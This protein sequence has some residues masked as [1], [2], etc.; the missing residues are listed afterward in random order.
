M[1]V[2]D[3]SAAQLF[4]TVRRYPRTLQL[5]AFRSVVAG[6][7][8]AILL[9][10]GLTLQSVS[11]RFTIA[12]VPATEAQIKAQVSKIK[13]IFDGDPY[14]DVSATEYLAI[15]NH[16]NFRY[17]LTNVVD[18][19]LTISPSRPWDQEISAQDGPAWG[20]ATNIGGGVRTANLEITLAGGATIDLIDPWAEVTEAEPM[21]RH[22]T[23]R[24]VSSTFAAAGDVIFSDWPVTGPD[25]SAYALHIDKSGGTGNLITDLRFTVDQAEEIQRCKYGIIQAQFQR[26]GCVQQ[27][28]FTH[29]PFARRGRPMEGLPMIF[30]DARLLLATS[31]ALNNT[32]LLIEGVEGV[33]PAPA[34]A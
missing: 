25:V 28:G 11:L 1:A 12:G 15:A 31:A 19:V 24:R 16:W 29:I 3:R 32:N 8:S 6:Q 27:T 33:D 14:I 2:I 4:R 20:L 23:I 18:G 9:P 34:A 13:F 30:Q 21:G 17:G 7:P 26:Y 22:Y 5:P 10:L